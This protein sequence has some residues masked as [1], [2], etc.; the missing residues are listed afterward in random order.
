L[1]SPEILTEDFSAGVDSVGTLSDGDRE[2]ISSLDPST[3]EFFEYPISGG[4]PPLP[5][6]SVNA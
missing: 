2:R 5:P 6:E 1:T 3:A 4:H